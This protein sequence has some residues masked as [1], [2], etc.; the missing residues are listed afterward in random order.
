MGAFLLLTTLE[1]YLP[2]PPGGGVDPFWYPAFYVLKVVVVTIVAVACRTAWRDLFPWPAARETALAVVVGLAVTILWV[3]CERWVPYPK[4]GMGGTRQAFDPF[5]LPAPTR[6]AFLLAR[7]Y[8]LVV[9]VPLVEELF[10]RSFLLRWIIDPNFQ[11]VPIGRVTW[12]AG[13]VTAALF[14]AAHPEWLPALLTG[15]AWAWLL[16][17]TRSVS[18][19]LISHG[20]ANLALGAYI[21]AARAWELW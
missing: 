14:A 21:L 11:R 19:C 6:V 15:A 2:Q 10:W 18:A 1:G 7:F 12:T 8:G 20:V 13:A 16:H 3:A 4:P 17:E 9:L 5:N